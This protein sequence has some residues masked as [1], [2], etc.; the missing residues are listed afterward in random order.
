MRIFHVAT[1]REWQA[2]RHTGSYR[3]S[4]YGRSL[5]DEGFI[6]A[7]RHEQVP[8]V[9]ARYYA[10]VSEPLV[11]LEIETELLDVGWQEDLVG[12]ETFPHIYGALAPSAVVGWRP[13][14]PRDVA[15]V[16]SG[17]PA[18]PVLST[19]FRGLCL[20]F[21]AAALVCVVCAI[22]AGDKAA[23]GSLPNTA[24]FLLWT[25]AITATACA[26]TCWG[27]AEAVRRVGS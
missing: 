16:S 6:H 14:R 22:V 25:G 9:L 24:E 21:V 27:V 17:R 4:T 26:L 10:E 19:A 7:A 18:P 15:E 8:G 23:N 2:A 5:R 12:G 20:V 1:D 3:T 11:L 13:A